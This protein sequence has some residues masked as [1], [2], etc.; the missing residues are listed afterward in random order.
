MSTRIVNN[1]LPAIMLMVSFASVPLTA[2]E[3][4]EADLDLKALSHAVKKQFEDLQNPSNGGGT[5]P[6][7]HYTHTKVFVAASKAEEKTDLPDIVIKGKMKIGS[8]TMLFI[9]RGSFTVGDSV[10]GATIVDIKS[11]TCVFSFGSQQFT[12]PIP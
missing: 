12:R 2:Q 8:K 1:V 11:D 3:T 7:G 5:F 6:F 9:D 10:R 4:G